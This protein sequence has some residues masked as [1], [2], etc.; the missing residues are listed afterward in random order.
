MIKKTFLRK[1]PLTCLAAVVLFV[2]L[3]TFLAS[4]LINYHNLSVQQGV[5]IAV[6][7]SLFLLALLFY[8]QHER[9]KLKMPVE[10]H[11]LKLA[12]WYKSILDATPFPI[13]VTDTDMNWTFIN[14]AVEEFLGVKREDIL[15]KPCSNWNAHICNTDDCGISCAKRGL[16][17]TFFNQYGRSHQVDV[18][19][20]RNME[21]EIA[22]FIEVVQDVTEMEEMHKKQSDAEAA[23]VAKSEFLANMSHEMRT[24]MNAIIGM[25]ELVLHEEIPSVVLEHI[26][27]IK[28]AGS[29]LLSIINDILDFSKIETGK[30]E[31]IPINYQFSS[32]ITDVVSII[33]TRV[34]E[35]RLRFV[36]NVNNEIP[37]GLFGDAVRIRQIMLNL[38]SN[39][40]KYTERGFI[41]LVIDQEVVSRNRI[42]LA[43]RVEDSGKGIK[44]EEIGMLF[45]EFTRV[46]IVDN[47]GIEGTGL[48]LAITRNLVAAMAGTIDVQSDYGQGSVFTVTLPQEVRDHQKLAVVENPEEKNVLIYERR[49]KCIQSI[50]HTMD[51]LGV[52]YK[53][54]SNDSEFYDA[55]MSRQY[56]FVFLASVLYERVKEK[57]AEFAPNARFLLIAEFGET[58]GGRNISILTTP[59]YS[60]PVANFLN[61]VA[62]DFNIGANSGSAVKFTAPEA[63]ILVVD[64]IETNLKVARGLLRPYGM[65][66]TSCKSGREAIEL[67]QKEHYDL[68]LMD[69]MM[70]EMDGM[71][72]VKRIREIGGMDPYY[73]N[74]P[75]IALTANAV[76]G[77]KEMFLEN[78][79]D[80]FL[81]KPIDIVR[82]NTV[83]E[84][85]LLREK[86]IPREAITVSGDATAGVTDANATIS[87]NNGLFEIDGLNARKGLA[88][89]SGQIHNYLNTLAIF[90]KDAQ[91]K[92]S[93]LKACLAAEDLSLYA[94]HAH[95]LKGAA[96]NIG[97]EELSEKAKSLETAAK[98]GDAAFVHDHSEALFRS[99][100]A[101]LPGIK[102]AVKAVRLRAENLE[103]ITDENGLM[104]WAMLK[105]EIDKLSAGLLAFDA[106]TINQ[107]AAD[108]QKF[109][110]APVVGTKVE[111]I[112]ENVLIGEYDE[113]ASQI[114]FI[115]SILPALVDS[116]IH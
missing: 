32:M 116:A 16:N 62:E 12:H 25:S 70:P 112:L 22:G 81:S 26:M 114:E 21:G 84:K 4:W 15:G 60:L 44:Q 96:A 77:T 78:G 52:N 56:N 105:A 75:I 51:S 94:I 57:Y 11:A 107:T 72:A 73:R 103:G 7:E 47:I 39:A 54:V 24:P 82:L 90:Q 50:V 41:S 113:A 99:L 38:L 76:S 37:N 20:L 64:D 6:G 79:F 8:H 68:V 18:E 23:S 63:L 59:I 14:K 10:A 74:V 65:Q 1:L 40:V 61:S 29:N 102:A 111:N 106:A 71:E 17:R 110:Q 35:S 86:Q 100:A 49:E 87:A 83:L 115:D 5:F 36:V 3:N 28:Q 92:S 27:T 48:G 58:I 45:N 97:A 104:D 34:L 85:W 69:H 89:S 2:L 53:L 13:T 93:E 55:V 88:I 31:I 98:Q 9:N 30:L 19:I 101:L 109:T 33:K 66:V 46:D 67:I 80:D 43:I 91:E 42:V 95:A 108:L